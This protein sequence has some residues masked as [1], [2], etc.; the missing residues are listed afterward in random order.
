VDTEGGVVM[1]VSKQQAALNRQRI[2]DSAIKLFGERGVDSVGVA[3]VMADAGFT[4]GGFYNHF[5]SKDDLVLQA[6]S[7]SLARSVDHLRRH[8][9]TAR[10][11]DLDADFA[12]CLSAAMLSESSKTQGLASIYADGLRAFL[13]VLTDQSGDRPHAVS[14]LARFVGALVISRAVESADQELADEFADA[15]PAPS[16]IGAQPERLQANS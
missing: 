11:D 6:C 3:E 4:H 10:A 5:N 9:G 12:Q 13:D 15:M 16:P 1:R 14:G 8:N 7:A 2:V